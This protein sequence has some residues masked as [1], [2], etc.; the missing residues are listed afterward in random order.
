MKHLLFVD[1]EIR[2]LEGLRRMLRAKRDEW[3][4]HYAGGVTEALAIVEA[5]PLSA[6]VTDINM[7]GRNGLELLHEIKSREETKFLPVLMLT[8]NGDLEVKRQ[9][10]TLGATDFLN[11]PFDFVEM[12][13][14]LQNA[15]SLKDFQDEIRRQNL[16][17]EERVADRTKDLE[18]SRKDIIFR[19]A[20]AAETRDVNTGHHIVRVGIISQMIA[21]EMGFDEAFQDQMLLTAPLH[22]VGKIAIS[23]TILQKPGPLDPQERATMEQHCDVGADILTEDLSQVFEKMGAALVRG[24]TE[25][26]LL[27]IAARIAKSH[28]EHWDGRGY[29]EGLAG[30]AIPLEARIVSVADVYDALRS[31]RPYKK[32]FSSDQAWDVIRA[33]ANTQFDPAVV[34]AFGS[35][36]TQVETRLQPL[37]DVELY[38]AA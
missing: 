1:D 5:Q 29:P 27:E 9:A 19:L 20:K 37:R 13:V 32:S 8:G 35:V 25:N 16:L 3:E 10:L 4:C 22:D 17:L 2:V 26:N 24:S 7:P 28:H 33:G 11:K 31:A 23:D 12:V 34:A 15:I 6:V 36:R 21:G 30:G 38:I 14:R 18:V